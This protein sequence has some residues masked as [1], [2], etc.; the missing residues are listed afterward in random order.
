MVSEKHP[1][2]SVVIVSYVIQMKMIV[3]TGSYLS[4]R[5]AR[6]LIEENMTTLLV[7]LKS[8]DVKV[9]T[10]NYYF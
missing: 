7:S 6:P 2:S 5:G 4:A 8:R 10:E 9:K 1:Y 3:F